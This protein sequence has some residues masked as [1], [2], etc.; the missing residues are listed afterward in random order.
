[1]LFSDDYL[2]KYKLQGLFR[3]SMWKKKLLHEN[4]F[5]MVIRIKNYYCDHFMMTKSQKIVL[6]SYLGGKLELH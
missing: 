3:T 2:F 5:I 1:M 4:S 6:C